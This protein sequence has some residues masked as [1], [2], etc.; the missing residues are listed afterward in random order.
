MWDDISDRVGTGLRT[1]TRYGANARR[2]GCARTS[3]IVVS[4]RR[5]GLT[6][7]MADIEW[8]VQYLDDGVPA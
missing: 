1:V 4:I 7:S 2:R 5:D 3:G 6:A 8:I